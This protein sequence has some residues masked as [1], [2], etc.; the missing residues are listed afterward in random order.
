M[1]ISRPSLFLILMSFILFKPTW[2]QQA[3]RPATPRQPARQSAPRAANGQQVPEGDRITEITSDRL[4]FDYGNKIAIFTGN[5]VVSDPDMQLNADKMTIHLTRTDE[6][7]K[8][9]AIGNVVIRMEGLNSRSGS[10]VYHLAEQKI[11]LEDEP[12]VFREQSVLMA[13]RITYF[14][15]EE[16]MTAEPRPRLLM[17]Q[18]AERERNLQF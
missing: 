17:F 16:R 12:Q 8:I 11:V 3:P 4:L 18:D 2:A 13:E 14:R 6:V 15:L 1:K 7:E 10:A 5:V 9:V